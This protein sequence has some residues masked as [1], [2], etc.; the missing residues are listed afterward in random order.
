M[1]L[2]LNGEEVRRQG[3]PLKKSARNNV[4]DPLGDR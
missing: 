1:R 4:S 2:L 3:N